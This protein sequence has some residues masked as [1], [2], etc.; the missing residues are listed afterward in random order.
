MDGQRVLAVYENGVFRPVTMV[1]DLQE[2]Q[3]VVLTVRHVEQL[4]PAEAKRR[5]EEIIRQMEEAGELS[6]P[7]PPDEPPPKDWKPLVIEGEPLSE[8]IIRMRG[9]G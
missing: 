6:H 3:Q 4:D 1:L 9:E 5:H 7:P 8:T 2:G